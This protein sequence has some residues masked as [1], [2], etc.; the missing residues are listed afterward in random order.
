MTGVL[1]QPLLCAV[2]EFQGR[3]LP[4]SGAALAYLM[5]EALMTP[6]LMA[7]RALFAHVWAYAPSVLIAWPAT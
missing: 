4:W 1:L 3:R 6:H 2:Q 7:V 5:L